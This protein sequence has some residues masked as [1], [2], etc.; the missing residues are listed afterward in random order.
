MVVDYVPK[1]TPLHPEVKELRCRRFA[2]YLDLLQESSITTTEASSNNAS[3]QIP[4]Y[5]YFME[6]V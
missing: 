5:K 4:G 2:G 6:Q 1:I 3:K